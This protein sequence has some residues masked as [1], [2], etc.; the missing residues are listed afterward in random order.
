M[1]LETQLPTY[2]LPIG[3]SWV[4]AGNG[5]TYEA[6]NPFTGEAWALVSNA[7]SA[8]VDRAVAAARA[9]LNGPWGRMTGADRAEL[10]RRLAAELDSE[11]Q[12]LATLET[13]GN[14]KLIRETS[15]QAQA[16]SAYYNYFAGMADKLE[17]AS[18]PAH[19]PGY[20]LYTEHSPV[21]V[22][23]AIMAW[24]SPLLLMTW[25]VA[26]ALAAGCTIIAKPSPYTP[27]STLAFARCVER[28]GFPP[29][30]FN[31]LT[32][33]TPELGPSLVGHPGID[34]VT[35]TGST[36]TGIAVGKAA[37]ET[38]TRVSLELG[39]KSAQIVFADADLDAA[40]TG[41][42]AGVF[43]AT[44]QTCVAGSRLLVQ[45]DV[46]DALVD[47][48]VE[49]AR[50]IRLGDPMDPASEMGPLANA[51]QLAKVSGLMERARAEGAEVA[52]G[53]RIAP[54]L[55]GLFYEPTILT[56]I[57][58]G[59]EIAREEVFGP[60]LCVLA[61]DDED[62]A[63]ELANASEFGLA[64][65]IWTESVRRAHR[66]A[67]RVQAGSVWVNTYRMV[68]PNAPFGG[69][70]MSGIGRENGRDAVQA[71]TELKTVWVALDEA[72][73][74]DPFALG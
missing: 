58:P 52:H 57:R 36:Q 56:G 44:G 15:G 53:G 71:F 3:G 38:M 66:V 55:G 29:G 18:I 11:A 1:S 26:P 74:R 25:K 20:L 22:V 69:F 28:A 65:G 59:M 2:E 67:R 46:H 68:A 61:F 9:A 6:L 54:A 39:G 62:E 64:A 30:V 12:E 17:G 33:T 35:F 16:L 47:R 34:K 37:M 14:G 8:D 31:V 24:N 60:V 19:K 51:P 13:C 5:A 70:K 63:V 50:R 42:V 4:P 43:A 21:G 7:G 73:A 32:G 48:L 10:M 45:R 49:F 40:A 72:E 41:V 27:V 23:A